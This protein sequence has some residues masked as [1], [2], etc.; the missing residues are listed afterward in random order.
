MIDVSIVE[1][2]E[3]RVA[4]LEHHG[5]PHLEYETSRKFIAWRIANRLPPDRHRT[6]GIHYTDPRTTP[7]ED[8]RMDLCVSVD[9][10][11]PVNPEGVLNKVIAGGRYAVTRHI[12]SR[13]FIAA[14]AILVEQ[15]LPTSGESRRDA[16]MFFHYVNVGPSVREHEMITD[17]YLP[18]K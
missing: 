9:A 6:F 2:P 8:H 15:W 12:G 17:V 11:V 7:P 16:P 18:L 10:P 3:T 4:A 5:P 1:F 14:A 13:E